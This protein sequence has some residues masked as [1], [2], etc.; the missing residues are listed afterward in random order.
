MGGL[1][2]TVRMDYPLRNVVC[3]RIIYGNKLM[4]IFQG[5]VAAG[6]AWYRV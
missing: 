4:R 5:I 2:P 3:N 6:V 1:K